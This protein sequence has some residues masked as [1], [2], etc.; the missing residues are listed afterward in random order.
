MGPVN[1]GGVLMAK[2]D[3]PYSSLKTPSVLINMDKLEA[4]IKRMSQPALDAGLRLR[5]HVKVHQTATIARMQVEAGAIGIEVGPLEQAEAM[6]DEGFEDIIVA[7][8]FYGDHKLEVL[9]RLLSRPRLKIGVVVDMLQQAEAIS[10]L[11]QTVGK[12][13]PVYMKVEY[14]GNSRYGVLPGEP[15]LDLARNLTKLQGIHF[16]GIYAHEMGATP[17][18]EGVENAAFQCASTVAET[19]R[20]LRVQGIRVENASVGAS[21]TYPA[22]CRYVREGKLPEITEVHPGNFLIGDIG[23]MMEHANS[24]E[25]C[26]LTVLVAVMSSSHPGFAIVDAGYKTFGA[27]SLIGFQET[28]GF[29]WDGKPSF[30]SVEGR[31]DLWLGR[32]CAEVS[33]VY[34]T[35]SEKRLNVGDRLEIVPNTATLVVNL[36]DELYVVRNGVIEIVM[37]ITGRGKGN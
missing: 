23:Y 16:L 18:E 31:P 35:D 29:F 26:A 15:V 2:Q 33:C 27:D 6:A 3:I 8:P 20:M 21:C 10:R 28:P 9:K 24:R 5:P 25:T 12:K 36:H 32:L 7:H 4:N 14:G 13:V 37:P 1:D 11:G 30:G 19:V 17:T 22:T 34:Y